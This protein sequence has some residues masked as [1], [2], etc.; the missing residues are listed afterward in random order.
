MTTI[1]GDEFADD[2]RAIVLTPEGRAVFVPVSVQRRL[3]GEALEVYAEY[4]RVALEIDKLERELDRLVPQA[5]AVGLSW[6][7]LGSPI[8][9]TGE[10]A[11]LRYGD[12]DF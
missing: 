2:D 8:G 10:G 12:R 3:K 9:L 4:S 6:A 5:R 11:R 7:L 1:T